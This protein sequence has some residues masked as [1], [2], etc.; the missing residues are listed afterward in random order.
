M[1]WSSTRN[2][3]GPSG[4]PTGGPSDAAGVVG[5]GNADTFAT[6]IQEGYFSLVALN[7]AD[8]TSLDQR[9]RRRPAPQ[10]SLPQDRGRTVRRGDPPARHWRLRHLAIRA[11]VVSSQRAADTATV[12][13][14]VT[15]AA[16]QHRQRRLV[17]PQPP[18]D[19]EKYSYVRAEPALPDDRHPH[20][21]DAASSSARSG[22]RHMT[23][24]CCRSWLFTAI[25]VIYQVI[26]LPVNF[27]G[28]GFDL[29]AHQARIQAWCP[30]LVSGRG[31]LPAHLR[32]ADRTAPQH[33]DRRLGTHRGLRGAKRGPTSLTTGRPR[34]PARWPRSFGF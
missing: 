7:F 21:L 3:V 11:V 18:D 22:S 30:P 12:A 16:R 17:P 1:R 25:Y 34:R 19:D 15:A 23:W 20:R 9:H 5:A 4:A 10:P 33:L 32:R 2:I 14:P 29:A 8:T 6:Y 31:H 27:A 28:R 13:R 24:R 26:S